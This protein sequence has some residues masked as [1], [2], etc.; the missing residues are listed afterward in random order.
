MVVCFAGGFSLGFGF[1]KVGTVFSKGFFFSSGALVVY[2]FF[3]STSHTLPL[4]ELD[5][6]LSYFFPYFLYFDNVEVVLVYSP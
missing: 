4:L 5:G 1:P 6:F 2:Y 3:S